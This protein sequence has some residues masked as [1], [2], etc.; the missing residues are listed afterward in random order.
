MKLKMTEFIDKVLNNPFDWCNV[1]E[2]L[3]GQYQ[4][5]FKTD[6]FVNNN[7]HQIQYLTLSFNP[8]LRVC[9]ITTT[10]ETMII[11]LNDRLILL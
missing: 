10:Q 9:G 8:H 2:T 6:I 4:I 1:T 3:G 5:T 7:E 11:S